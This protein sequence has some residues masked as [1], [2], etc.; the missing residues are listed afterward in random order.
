MNQL[1]EYDV[2]RVKRLDQPNRHYDGTENIKH[3]PRI[4]DL[5]TIVHVYSDAQDMN[6]TYIVECVDQNGLT[7]WLADFTAGELE[8]VEAVQQ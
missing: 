6:P 7:V 2:V 1:K 8:L 4:G 3:L 5:G